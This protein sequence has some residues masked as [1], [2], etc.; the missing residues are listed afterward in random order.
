[1]IRSFLFCFGLFYLNLTYCQENSFDVRINAYAELPYNDES[2]ELINGWEAGGRF[3]KNSNVSSGFYINITNFSP[4]FTVHRAIGA[5][6]DFQFF[7]FDWI[8]FQPY[9]NFG[10]NYF[11]VRAQ[12]STTYFGMQ[13]P[14]TFKIDESSHGF[15]AFGRVGTL[16]NISGE[17]EDFFIDLSVGWNRHLHRNYFRDLSSFG[18]NLGL[19][20]R[21]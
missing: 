19:M 21:F 2:I 1:M 10:G 12:G 13:S 17:Q 7:L 15:K 3:S 5:G 4:S 6:A 18:L 20:Y 16:F 14:I 11:R 8:I 9:L